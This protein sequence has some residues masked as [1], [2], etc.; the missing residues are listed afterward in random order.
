VASDSD[1]EVFEETPK[2]TPREKEVLVLVLEGKTSKEAGAALGLST[3]TIE[4]HLGNIYKK[5]GVSSKM[6]AFREVRRL[7]LLATDDG[8]LFSEL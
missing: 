6:Q 8:F 4:Y 7:G 2:L 5:L 1:V 3:R